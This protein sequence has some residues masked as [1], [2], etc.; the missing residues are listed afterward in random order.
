MDVDQLLELLL[1]GNQLKRTARTGWVQR[2]VPLPE[3]V[4]AHTFGVVYATLL[5][6]EVVEQPIDL[7]AALAMAALHDL[8]EGLTTDIPT[9]AWRFL[10]SGAKTSAERQAM[11]QIAGETPTGGR[12]L[13]WWEELLANETAEAHLVHDA[14][15]LDQY[16]Q[17]VVYEQ[18]T[19]NRLLQEFWLVAHRFHYPQAQAVYDEL[20]RRV[21]RS[22]GQYASTTEH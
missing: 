7:A 12:L 15:K 21:S 10:P 1:H 9:P 13:A 22:V 16:L 3:N 14:D 20:R 8:P 19:G 4:A 5:L 11:A 2:G 17:A 6:A 18:Q